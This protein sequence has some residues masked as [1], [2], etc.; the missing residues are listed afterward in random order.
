MSGGLKERVFTF[1]TPPGSKS[2]RITNSKII[3]ITLEAV[4]F[5]AL[6]SRSPTDP[7]VLEPLCNIPSTEPIISVYSTGPQT[8]ILCSKT[9]ASFYTH[10]PDDPTDIRPSETHGSF[11]YISPA[12]TAVW[13]SDMLILFHDDFI[14]IW[15][16]T[17]YRLRQIIEG[18]DIRCVNTGDE[19]A[20]HR[21]VFAM[22]D[23]LNGRREIVAELVPDPEAV[24]S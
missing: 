19:K 3:V 8:Y 17:T 23:P 13:H 11:A 18:R 9:S 15:D 4:H 16:G 14:E 2:A 20:G 7:T 6:T 22:R 21:V 10:S 1:T 24:S 12:V 5:Y